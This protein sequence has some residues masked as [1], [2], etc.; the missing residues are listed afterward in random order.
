MALNI[1]Q[2]ITQ[3]LFPEDRLSEIKRSHFRLLD[4]CLKQFGTK[5]I[6]IV[7][8]DGSELNFNIQM[9][10]NLQSDKNDP[11]INLLI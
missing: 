8:I 2:T 7:F 10:K 11:K 9:T 1:A 5:N 3:T 4:D 6:Q